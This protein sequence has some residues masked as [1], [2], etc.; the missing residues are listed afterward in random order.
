[1][2][3]K[4]EDS[5]VK[6]SEIYL[7]QENP[8]F[9][10]VNDQR[11]AVQV[12]LKEQGDKIINLAT[13][14][15]QNGL[16]P[17]SKLILFVEKKRYI[18]GDGNR[19]LTALKILETP[20]LA[21]GSPRIR[22]KIEAVLKGNGA[23]PTEVGCVIFKSREDARHWISINHNGPQEGKGQ[24]AWDSEQK[25]RFEG[26]YTIGL[27]ALDQL[28]HKG[29]I[30]NE[31]KSR[32]NK[33]TLDRLLSYKEVKA[34]LIISK[35]GEHFSFG[36]M[37]N[38]QIVCLALR[39]KTVDVVYTAEK[40]IKFI[41]DILAGDSG[42]FNPRN[43]GNAGDQTDLEAV[44]SREKQVDPENDKNISSQTFKRS[45]RTSSSEL[46]AFGGI[47]QLKLGPVNN[48]YR[49]IDLLFNIYK[50]KL[51]KDQK[52]ILGD[53]FV[54]IF[55]MSLRILAETAANETNKKLGDYLVEYFDQA[56]KMLDKDSKTLLSNQ[57]VKKDK[58]VELFQT[59][60][61]DYGSSKNETQA[62]A[63]SIILGAIL[64]ITHG[65]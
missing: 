36:H 60:A 42:N 46:P 48:I 40:G 17:S 25:N 38:L 41:N 35:N 50:G 16:N 64:K 7:D 39:D 22:K 47:L 14:I 11:E 45:R 55:R 31:D 15:Y 5:I 4:Y 1:M 53:G 3:T 54:V 23:T 20:S 59:G 24:I 28:S 21:D 32:I 13:D 65:K 12:M 37:N 6:V 61:H 2:K 62:V 44:D 27:Q 9:P 18:D 58:I 52:V 30:S 56:K 51:C 8:R 34:K 63:L 57:N 19:R 26:K 29:L 43:E 49:D 33:T 10:P